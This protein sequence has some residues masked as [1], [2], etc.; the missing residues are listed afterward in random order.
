V[1]LRSPLL[2][3]LILTLGGSLSFI[4]VAFWGKFLVS[5]FAYCYFRSCFA[6]YILPSGFFV[7]FYFSLIRFA[8]VLLFLGLYM[9]SS[10]DKSPA[11]LP[12]PPADSLCGEG[13]L[14]ASRRWTPSSTHSF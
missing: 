9:D 14:P 5:W 13:D 4:G 10:D 2:L 11:G 1:V 6:F 3:V 8:Y 7:F 12:C